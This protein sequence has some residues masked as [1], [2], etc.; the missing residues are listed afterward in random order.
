MVFLGFSSK[1]SKAWCMERRHR[2]LGK[3]AKSCL[4]GCDNWTWFFMACVFLMF[5]QED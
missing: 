4:N 5:A 1:I 3:R 2:Q